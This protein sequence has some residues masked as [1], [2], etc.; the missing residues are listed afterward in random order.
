[1]AAALAER[2]FEGLQAD[3]AGLAPGPAIAANAAA[4]IFQRTATSADTHRPRALRGIVPDGYDAVVAMDSD[5]AEEVVRWASPATPI[6]VW[7]IVDPYGGSLDDYWA[8]ADSIEKLLQE[9]FG[10]PAAERRP[11]RVRDG[12]T[13]RLAEID[14]DVA[15]WSRQVADVAPTHCNGIAASAARSLERLLKQLLVE[16]LASRGLALEEVLIEIHFKGSVTTARKLPLGTVISALD[17]LATRDR[18]LETAWRRAAQPLRVFV[19]TRNSEIH[20]ADRDAMI[21]GTRK[22][23]S[24]AS[25]ALSVPEFRALFKPS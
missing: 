18:V 9:T 24:L 25:E 17:G 6:Y 1:M 5:V 7:D 14:A 12:T 8:V 10:A 15:R 19:S 22:L 23:L 20:D 21:V 3:S 4:V 13:D 11:D 2:L 16:R